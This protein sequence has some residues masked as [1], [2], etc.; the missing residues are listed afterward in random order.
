[1]SNSILQQ[2]RQKRKRNLWPCEQ[3]SDS[4]CLRQRL[5]VPIRT[6]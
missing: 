3:V 2:K 5:I 4:S 6:Q 1:M